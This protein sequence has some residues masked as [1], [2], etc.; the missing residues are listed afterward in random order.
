MSTQSSS[1]IGASSINLPSLKLIPVEQSEESSKH[2]GHGQWLELDEIEYIVPHT[3]ERKGWEVCR[4]KKRSKPTSDAVDAVDLHAIIHSSASPPTIVLVV[5]YRP[6]INCYCVEFP[7]GL[8]DPDETVEQAAL[9]ELRE[10]TGYTG[11]VKS[12]SDAVC[13]E[14]GL[15]DSKTKVVTV[16][17]IKSSSPGENELQELDDDEW[18]L[19]VI[20]VPLNNLFSTLTELKARNPST[21]S[22]D[23]RLYAYALGLHTAS[24]LLSP[25]Q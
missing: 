14:P 24:T 8:I 15:T 6:P 9:R 22:I 1:Q 10:E 4:R 5:Q 18:S 25:S 21:L 17:I 12:V 23:S 3:N 2:L 13:Y 7:S 19:H 11:I 16:E 20:Q